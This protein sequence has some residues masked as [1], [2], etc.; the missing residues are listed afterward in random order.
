M[1]ILRP[2]YEFHYDVYSAQILYIFSQLNWAAGN[3][4]ELKCDVNWHRKKEKKL[5][6]MQF[7][8]FLRIWLYRYAPTPLMFWKS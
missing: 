2:E 5:N 4:A 6:F 8:A 3:S 7:Y 1:E